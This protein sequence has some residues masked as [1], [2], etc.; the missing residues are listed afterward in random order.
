MSRT[1][2]IIAAAT[3]V[4][5]TLLAGV[6]DTSSAGASTTG[7][8]DLSLKQTPSNGT[9]SGS[10]IVNTVVHN[11]G[12]DTANGL[13]VTILVK[14]TS[15]LGLG[16]TS[17]NPSMICQQQ[18][19][20]PGWAFM[21]NCQAPSLAAGSNWTLTE[22]YSGTAGAAFTAFQ[23]VGEGSP[24]DPSL[25]NNSSTLKTYFGPAADLKLT[26]AV[27]PGTSSGTVTITDTAR[28]LGP[29]T[30]NTLQLVIEINS[31]GFSGVNA[32]SSLPASCQFIAPDPG[33]NAAASCTTSNSLAPLRNWTVTFTYTGTPGGSL[34]QVGTVTANN[35]PD[36][37][38]ANSSATTNTNYAS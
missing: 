32:S 31:P 20:P 30:A 23:S 36:P 9:S 38:S 16:V 29:W 7:A 24:G 4:A 18:P 6:L 5:G 12:P 21:F 8:A 10:T 27:T 17:N 25:S 1:L 22:T 19:A 15:A 28:N 13:D 11:A 35:P 34:E 2:R 26:Q 37:N 3:L 14:T 33:F